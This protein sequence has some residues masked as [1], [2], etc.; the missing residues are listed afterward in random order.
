MPAREAPAGAPPNKD[1][2]SLTE[3]LFRQESGRLVSILTR[4][5]GFDRIELAEEVVQEALARALQTWPYY[6]VPENPPAWLLQTA[7]NLA[8]DVVRREK[9]FS[10]KQ[11]EISEVI[12]SWT[13]EG[14]PDRSVRLEQEIKDNQLR[15][16]FACCHPEIPQE[17]Q[18]A[19]AL[20]TLCGFS[21]AEI[22]HAYLSTEAAIAKRL[23]RAR[24]RIK[25][26][27]LPFEIPSGDELPARLNA[28]LQI[29][30][31]LFNEG[32]KAS[33]GESL[34]RKDLCREAIRL[35]TLLAQHPVTDLPRCHALL[36]LMLFHAARLESRVGD[37][38][39][40]LRLKEQDRQQWD[41]RMIARAVVEL[42]RA[43]VGD[44]ISV[45][46]L[47]AGI[48]AYHCTAPDY[49]S[50]N[51]QGIL[52]L[53]D[54]LVQLDA[55]PILQLNR[56]VAISRVAGPDAGIEAIGAITN[57]EQIESYYLY[58]AVLGELE[59]QRNNNAAA[60]GHFRRALGFTD[61]K[62]ERELLEKRLQVALDGKT[63]E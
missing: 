19:L 48:A 33:S 62:S 46:H 42:G 55:S 32:Y 39:Q 5:F 38:G 25:E 20:R 37:A 10:D 35:A 26:L 22:A 9:R 16:M 13:S 59:L 45:Y 27:E 41:R 3:S 44:V 61:M 57:R 54:K 1:I 28:V 15:L 18:T 23:V 58:D 51:W 40:V 12:E 60:A 4:I 43:S 56:A 31:L 29:L 63:K 21:Q 8:L 30:Y 49:E 53:Y 50:T 24:Q 52:D 14:T 7:R 34:V 6:G 36:S 11:G 2:P 17:A 47:Q